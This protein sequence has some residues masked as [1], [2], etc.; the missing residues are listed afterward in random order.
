MTAF[1][2]ES[3]LAAL[4]SMG[5]GGPKPL[6]KRAELEASEQSPGADVSLEALARYLRSA[7]LDDELRKRL[8][9]AVSRWDIVA[10]DTEWTGNT[11]IRSPDRRKVVFDGLG[12]S[13]VPAV[14]EVFS[15]LFPLETETAVA[16]P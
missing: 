8:H 10:P 11:A 9:L 4:G 3:Y 13:G 7:S 5:T 14:V 2:A 15:D 1:L 16:V 12:V 6:L